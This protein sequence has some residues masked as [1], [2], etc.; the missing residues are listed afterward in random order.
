MEGLPLSNV[1]SQDLVTNV[2]EVL[3]EGEAC[4]LRF[5]ISAYAEQCDMT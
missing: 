5:R 1:Q 3:D 2:E 4:P